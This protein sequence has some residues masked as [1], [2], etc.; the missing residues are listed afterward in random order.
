MT[1]A[2]TTPTGHVGSRTLQLLLQAG[3]R[4]RALLRDPARLD[5]GLHDLVDLAQ[6]DLL[7]PGFVRTAT[8]GVD[9]LLWITPENLTAADPLAEMTA[10]VA[11]GTAAVHANRIRHIV[12]ISS[13]GA[14]L[15]T[16]AGLIDGLAHSE[17]QFTA[18]G[19]HV[20]ILR[21]GY[22]YTN[23]LAMA[24]Q[25][26]TGTL[27]TT[28]DPD[29][30]MPWVDPRDVGEIAAARLLNPRT[31]GTTVQAVHGPADLTW[32]QAADILSTALDTKITLTVLPDDT[33]AAALTETGMTEPAIAALLAM[34]SG[35]RD[36]FTPEQPRTPLTTTPTTLHAW[37]TTNLRR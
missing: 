21:C 9:T 14:E 13:V 19:A 24:D 22:Y 30:P 10:I 17:Q 32:T 29:Q 12:L 11:A 18:T 28:A 36:G 25:L 3:V 15:R 37:A 35:L 23:L 16:G 26:H 8:E 20:H 34:T 2:V 4:P 1:I 27:T 5:P 7:D 33:M 6:G 31:T